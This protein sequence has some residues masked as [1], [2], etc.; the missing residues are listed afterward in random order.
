MPSVTYKTGF[1][2]ANG[3]EETLTEYLCDWPGCLDIA[4]HVVGC[5]KEIGVTVA[6]CAKHAT[7]IGTATGSV[8]IRE[9]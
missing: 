8:P 5:A 6:L 4:E 2:D 7:K 9:T 1:A 3:R